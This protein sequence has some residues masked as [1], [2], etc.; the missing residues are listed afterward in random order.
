MKT[1]FHGPASPDP[2]DCPAALSMLLRNDLTGNKDAFSDRHPDGS[3]QNINT[4]PTNGPESLTTIY[5]LVILIPVTSLHHLDTLSKLLPDMYVYISEGNLTY[6]CV[7]VCVK[8]II[9][10]CWLKSN[11]S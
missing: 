8:F 5:K 11:A 4:V 2:G 3:P 1:R 10:L 7:C 6:V 9:I